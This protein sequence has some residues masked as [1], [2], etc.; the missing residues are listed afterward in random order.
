MAKV[1][2]N[3]EIKD[4]EI[5]PCFT[6][7]TMIATDQ[8]E[9]AVE[10]LVAGDRVW[11]RDRGYQP[12]SWI[13]SRRLNAAALDVSPNLRPIRIAAGALGNGTPERDLVVSPQHR[14]LIRSAIAG[15]M[16]GADEV[17][18]GAK[19]L[20]GLPGITVAR[21]MA[22]VEYIHFLLDGHAIVRS[23][24]AE[25]ESLYLG[26]EALKGIPDA[27]RA[28]IRQLFPELIASAPEP[29]RHLPRGRLARKLAERHA[30]NERVLVS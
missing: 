11:T 19:H 12:I 18:V 9:V 15:R 10:D 1:G 30:A 16:F 6:P 7:G 24:G 25:T 21:D 2:F 26:P 27:A 5:A 13:G 3:P 22:Q 17:L 28:E 8:G 29:A 14:I 20:V 23:N 4:V